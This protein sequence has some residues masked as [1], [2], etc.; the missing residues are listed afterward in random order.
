MI[1]D[2]KRTFNDFET[3][4]NWRG[5]YVDFSISLLS[6]GDDNTVANLTQAIEQNPNDVQTLSD[7]GLAYYRR[8]DYN[9][10]IADFTKAIVW[11]PH[12]ILAL[13]KRGAAYYHIGD[14]EN[15]II[16]LN[17]VIGFDGGNSYPGAYYKRGLAYQAQYDYYDAIDDFDT[18]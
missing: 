5:D 15:A 11:D 16:D 18:V 2:C 6:W 17:Q 13:F 7:R 8:G 1:G 12:F 9:D 10:A 4:E 14:Y 3:V